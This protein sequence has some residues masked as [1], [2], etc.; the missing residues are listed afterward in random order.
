[1]VNLGITLPEKSLCDFVK[2][3]SCET[4][5]SSMMNKIANRAYKAYADHFYSPW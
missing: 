1:M 2:A 3:V 4:G 5:S